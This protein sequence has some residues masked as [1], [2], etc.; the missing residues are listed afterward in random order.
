[1]VRSARSLLL[2]LPLIFAWFLTLPAL[3]SDW[4]Q[5]S[6][7][8]LKMTSDPAAPDAPAV[9]LY[10]EEIV[11]DKEHF[12][13]VY[14]RIKILNEKGKEQFSDIEIPY[15]AGGSNVRAVE[16]RTIHADGTVIPF[17][18]KPWSKELEKS[19]GVKW[20]EKGFSM[21]D[22]QVGSIL[23]YRWDVQYDD[24]WFYPPDWILPQSVYVHKAH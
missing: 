2:S 17:T 13:R 18:G 22:V 14:A 20:M 1:M 11:N 8:E 7:D 21:P 5:P 6:P 23:E 16:G 15:E 24:N 4:T 19:G 3:A 9:Y 10:R 12:H